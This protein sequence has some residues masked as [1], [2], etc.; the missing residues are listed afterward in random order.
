VTLSWLSLEEHD[1]ASV[2]TAIAFLDGRLSSRDAIEWAL[3]LA[4]ED[5]V[6]RTA[7]HELLTHREGQD[8]KEP[9]L[10]AWR[11]IEESWNNP[12]LYNQ[13]S[14]E[15]YRAQHRLHAGDRSGSLIASIVELVAP[16][17]KIEKRTREDG[18]LSRTRRK[19]PRIDDLFYASISSPRLV[20]LNALAVDGIDDMPFLIQLA[21]ALD[22]SVYKGLDIARRIGWDGE[23]RL[24][25][26]GQMYRVE[27]IQ[28]VGD[29]VN[30]DI[31][32]FHDGIVPAVKLLQAV[33]RRI[34]VL[35]PPTSAGFVQHWK[36]TDDPIHLRLWASL[37]KN[38]KVSDADDVGEVLLSTSDRRFWNLHDFPE[39]AELRAIRFGDFAYETKVA[40]FKRI[41]KGPPASQWPRG[42]TPDKVKEARLYWSVRELRRIDVA[43]GELPDIARRWLLDNLEQFQDLVAMNTIEEGF[44]TAGVAHW[45]RPNPDD[46]FDQ[47]AGDKR[48]QALEVALSS[49]RVSWDNDPSERAGDWIREAGNATKVLLDFETVPDTVGRYPHV[50]ERF[51]WSHVPSSPLGTEPIDDSIRHEGERI[52]ALLLRLPDEAARQAIEGISHWLSTWEKVIIASDQL[53]PV[54]EKLWPIATDATNSAAGSSE[55]VDLNVVA[56]SA[57]DS[58][59]MD[60]DTLN[61]AAGRLVGLFLAACP[62]IPPG[63]TNPFEQSEI[64]SKMR[65]DVIGANGRAGLIAKHRLIEGLSYFLK[66]DEI[67]TRTNL[68]AALCAN[69]SSALALWRAIARRTQFFSVLKIIGVQVV[70]RVNDLRLGRDTRSSLLSSLVVESMHSFYERRDPAVSYPSLQQAIRSV[71]DEVR[72]RAAQTVQRFVSQMTNQ[73]LTDQTIATAESVF[74]ESARPFLQRVWPQERSLATPGVSAAFA[75]LP[76]TAKEAFVEAVDA[77]ERFLVPF[78][79]WSMSEY[80]FWGEQ[81]GQPRLLFI[82]SRAKGSAFL[83]L[84]DATV[85]TADGSVI[86]MDLADALERVR[87]VAPELEASTSFRRLA[88]AARRR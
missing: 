53:L 61:T 28:K 81:D 56:Q 33:V 39:I 23:E 41:R 1:R 19:R 27:Y 32:E 18:A 37:S 31:D 51:G 57:S 59:P 68:I 79:C 54:W 76:A 24:W 21:N 72:A 2:R 10:T 52:I 14:I 63:A 88:T 8:L 75:D 46:K 42:N 35:D 45:V 62:S 38:S 43:G 3:G 13:A 55:D 69:D 84:L 6:K 66:A 7:V 80:G 71:E 67:W 20:D 50:W 34:S 78:D 77:T 60:L 11:L 30:R 65:E 74:L 29:G 87:T 58:E 36:H 5:I 48:L 83:R 47:T 16:A 26:L 40:I 64:L 17:L 73:K 25:R 15:A 49:T 22:A 4:H 82:D 44:L 85:G 9:W 70:E 12:I 86:P